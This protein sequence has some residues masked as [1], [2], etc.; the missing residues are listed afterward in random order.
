MSRRKQRRTGEQLLPI[1]RPS[2]IMRFVPRPWTWRAAPDGR[3]AL[4][5]F[6]GRKIRELAAIIEAGPG[7]SGMDERH[8]FPYFIRLWARGWFSV[9]SEPPKARPLEQREALAAVQ[10]AA[11]ALHQAVGALP[12]EAMDLL[13]HRLTWRP[14]LPTELIFTEMNPASKLEDYPPELR[15]DILRIEK[16]MQA[17]AVRRLTAKALPSELARLAAAAGRARVAIKVPGGRPQRSYREPIED[18]AGIWMSATG[19]RPTITYDPYRRRRS[20]AFRDFVYAASKPVFPAMGSV[21]KLI[22]EAC[23]ACREVCTE[24]QQR[25]EH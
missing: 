25:G 24:R 15:E 18:L 10:K 21:D 23:R 6:P 8:A 5:A 13:T 4:R 3:D 16:T 2:C 12:K 17:E 9:E 7:F 20:G 22:E 11:E 1:A 19:E 14:G